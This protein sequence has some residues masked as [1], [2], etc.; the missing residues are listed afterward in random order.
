[1]LI[2]VFLKRFASFYRAQPLLVVEYPITYLNYV[3]IVLINQPVG[4][5]KK[6]LFE[7]ERFSV[8]LHQFAVALV[9][10]VR[11]YFALVFLFGTNYFQPLFPEVLI[12]LLLL[13][14]LVTLIQDQDLINRSLIPL[15]NLTVL[16]A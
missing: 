14:Q 8:L 11:V 12:P 2:Q 9:K 16:T 7:Q 10:L 15:Q 6:M 3:D 13:I 1:R 5:Q 4:I